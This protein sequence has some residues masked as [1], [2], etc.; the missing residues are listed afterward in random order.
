MRTVLYGSKG[1]I[2]TDNT[3]GKLWLYKGE[4]KKIN[5]NLDFTYPLEIPINVKSHNVGREIE[6]F[7]TALINGDKSPVSSLEGASTVAVCNAAIESA[8]T[9]KPVTIKYPEV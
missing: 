7:L 5:G 6:Q 2:I 8:R 4:G 1:T 3:H 9:D